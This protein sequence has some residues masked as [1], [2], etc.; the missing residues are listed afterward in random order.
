MVIKFFVFELRKDFYSWFYNF[1]IVFAI[2]A[3]T[4]PLLLCSQ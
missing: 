2:D 3:V 1:V 4:T